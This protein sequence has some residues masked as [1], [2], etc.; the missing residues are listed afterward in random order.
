MMA[1]GV[2]LGSLA[3]SW[4]G[5]ELASSRD[6]AIG[7]SRG[8]L[9]MFYLSVPRKTPSLSSW[10]WFLLSTFG[11][12]NPSGRQDVWTELVMLKE[13]AE[14]VEPTRK[15]STW[16]QLPRRRSFGRCK[17][18]CTHCSRHGVPAQDPLAAQGTAVL[19]E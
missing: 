11:E 16:S 1:H 10:T 9:R 18:G 8:K 2:F 6:L 3:R 14:L 13:G 17:A 5:P 4:P 15:P 7:G 12:H 19:A